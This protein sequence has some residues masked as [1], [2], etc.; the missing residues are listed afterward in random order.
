MSAVEISTTP[1][2][3][4]K[5]KHARSVFLRRSMTHKWVVAENLEQGELQTETE[6][7][8]QAKWWNTID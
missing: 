4:S 6:R 5:S 8:G 3:I 2:M 1:C 7:K